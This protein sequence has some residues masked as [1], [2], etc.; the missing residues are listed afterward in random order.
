MH[1]ALNH[2][3]SSLPDSTVIYPGHEYTKSNVAFGASVEPE[4]EK[5]AELKKF[6]EGEGVVTTGKFTIGDEKCARFH[7]THALC[8]LE[9]MVGWLRRGTGSTTCL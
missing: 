3:L 6:C 8:A 7:L 2:A 1:R 4:N 9:L 5:I